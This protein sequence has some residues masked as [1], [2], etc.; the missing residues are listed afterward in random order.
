MGAK[1]TFHVWDDRKNLTKAGELTVMLALADFADDD[2]FCWPAIPTIARKARMSE[3]TAR[4]WVHDLESRGLLKIGYNEARRGANTYRLYPAGRDAVIASA[5]SGADTPVKSEGAT[6]VNLTGGGVD[7]V[8]GG[9]QSAR[10]TPVKSPDEPT[11]KPKKEPNTRD[12]EYETSFVRPLVSTGHRKPD[13]PDDTARYIAD[14]L[15]G[16]GYY[17]TTSVTKLVANELIYRKLITSA[18]LKE[19]NIHHDA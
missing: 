18:R 9:S 19:R 14:C 6:P 16:T 8:G 3:T 10:G 4:R 12:G 5:K 13:L 15:N 1:Y 17:P 7:L 11:I 2:G